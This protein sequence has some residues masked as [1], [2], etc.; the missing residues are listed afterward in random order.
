MS[1]IAMRAYAPYIP[2]VGGRPHPMDDDY[3]E[4]VRSQRCFVAEDGEPVGLLVLVPSDDHLLLENVAVHP[5]RHGQGIGR[6]LLDHAEAFT[7]ELGL[8][9][10]RLYTNAAMTQNLE[11][12]ERRGYR[13]DRHE[14]VDGFN[15]VFL[16]KELV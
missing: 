10:V 6:A 7:R 15:R 1:E 13:V 3:A 8:P 11:M 9:A 14:T 16:S 5:A 2:L 12:Y 4:K